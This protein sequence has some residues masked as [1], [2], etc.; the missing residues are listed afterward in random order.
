MSETKIPAENPAQHSTAKSSAIMAAGTMVSRVLGFVRT[1]LLAVAIGANTTMGDIFEKANTIP[2]IIYLLLAGGVF[3][4]VLVPQIIKASRK[5]DG[6]ADFVSRLL[7]LTLLVL[8]GIALLATLLAGPIISVLTRDWTPVMLGLAPFSPSG[9]CRRF[10]STACMQWWARCS[11]PTGVSAGICGL[12]P[13]NNV[14]AIGTLGLYIALYGRYLPGRDDPELWTGAQTAYW[15]AA[16]RWASC[17]RPSSC[18]GR[19]A[20]WGWA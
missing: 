12:L 19:W 3:N 13:L 20:G 17:C 4:V 10:S 14:V 11:T 5:S 1:A 7:S 16:P 6:G 9:A 15:P 18:S 2:N 8:A